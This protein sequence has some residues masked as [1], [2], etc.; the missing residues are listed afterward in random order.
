MVNLIISILIYL[1]KLFLSSRQSPQPKIISSASYRVLP[2]REK[3]IDH[4]PEPAYLPYIAKWL[5]GVV[6]GNRVVY[7]LSTV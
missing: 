7:A 1:S 3:E 2:D 4:K 6:S 5:G